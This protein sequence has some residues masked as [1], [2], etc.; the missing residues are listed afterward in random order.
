M[1]SRRFFR[2][3]V[4]LPMHMEL[5]DRYGKQLSSERYHLINHEEEARRQE[6]NELLEVLFKQVSQVSVAALNVFKLLNDRLNF[7]WWILD[8]IMES[9]DTSA[10]LDYKLRQKKDAESIRPTSKKSSDIAPLILGLYDAIEDY[11]TELN[12]VMKNS[13]RDKV[14]SYQGLSQMRFDD[15]RYVTNLNELADSGVLPAN[16]LRLIVEKINLQAAVLEKLKIA[17]RKTSS[18]EEWKHYQIN[19]SPTGCSFL[20][21]DEYSLFSSMDVYMDIQGHTVLCRG[22]VVAQELVENALLASR[23]S[24]EFELLTGE[25]EQEITRFLQHNELKDSMTQIPVPYVA[26]LNAS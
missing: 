15:K 1:S 7:M 23:V 13:V 17:Y 16:I 6:I 8:F 4:V 9:E 18:P 21:N 26:P 11:I 22:K 3:D 19:L 12:T 10:Q 20:T 25:Q 14:F 5:V 2:Y 24:I